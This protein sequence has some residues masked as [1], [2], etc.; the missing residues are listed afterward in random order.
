MKINI[1][2]SVLLLSGCAST[3]QKESDVVTEYKYIVATP[4][5]QF[6]ELPVK[7]DNI[8]PSNATEKDLALWI[9]KSAERSIKMENNLKAIKEYYDNII[10]NLKIDKNQLIILD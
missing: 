4:P 2:L 10:K 6:V 3:I 7:V 8:D 1:I 5:K 9:A